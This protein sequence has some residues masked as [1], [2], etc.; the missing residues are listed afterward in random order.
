MA[1][2]KKSASGKSGKNTGK[3]AGR[4][5]AKKKTAKKAA[6]KK[7]PAKKATAKRAAVKKAPAKSP[8]KKAAVPTTGAKPKTEAAPAAAKKQSKSGFSSLDVNMGQVFALRPRVAM[9][10][11]PGDF[12]EARHLLE[13]E[14]FANADEATRAVAEKALELTHDGIIPGRKS[15][16]RR[17]L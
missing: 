4:K 5:V 1:A 12:R 7:A 16:N 15:R 6:A 14:P 9:S 10:F 2:K 8:A 11:R 3:K 13:E 17:R